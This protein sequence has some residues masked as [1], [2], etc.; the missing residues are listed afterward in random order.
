MVG[1][2]ITLTLFY[3]PPMAKMLFHMK[4]A[5]LLEQSHLPPKRAL[6]AQHPFDSTLELSVASPSSSSSSSP[7]SSPFLF[8]SANGPFCSL[9]IGPRSSRHTTFFLPRL[10]LSRSFYVV[11]RVRRPIPPLRGHLSLGRTLDARRL[12]SRSPFFISQSHYFSCRLSLFVLLLSPA[13]YPAPYTLTSPLT[14]S[15]PLSLPLLVLLSPLR[16]S[17]GGGSESFSPSSTSSVSTLFPSPPRLLTL[18]PIS[19]CLF[20]SLCLSF[21]W[22]R[23]RSFS[24]L[25]HAPSRTPSRFYRS[26]ADRIARER[27]AATAAAATERERLARYRETQKGKK[28]THSNG[29]SWSI[30]IPIR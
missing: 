10:E 12:S 7:P 6:L 3:Q 26:L 16:A 24:G 21:S 22:Y 17:T 4:R 14:Q 8:S 30:T 11:Q 27:F 18:G 5:L 13:L 2:S 29:Y 1:S 15:L 9:P 19:L 23:T 20:L 28:R 25:E